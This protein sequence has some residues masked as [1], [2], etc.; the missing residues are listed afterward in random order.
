M[1]RGQL[2][3]EKNQNKNE[4]EQKNINTAKGQYANVSDCLVG[5]GKKGRANNHC[6]FLEKPHTTV[7][8]SWKKIWLALSLAKTC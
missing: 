5:E 1:A 2:R 3:R 6:W 4:K 8:S 7:A